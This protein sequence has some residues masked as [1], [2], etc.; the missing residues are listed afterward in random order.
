MTAR[1]RRACARA[2]KRCRPCFRRLRRAEKPIMR[3][4][5]RL[6][7]ATILIA[8]SSA[9]AGCGSMGKFRSFRPARLPRHQEEAAGRTQA[10]FPRRR[11]GPRA[12]RAEGSL[13]GL[14]P[15]A[16]RRA[17]CAGDRCAAAA[18]AAGAEIEGLEVQGQAGGCPQRCARTA[19][20]D[21]DAA[22]EEEGGTAAAPPGAAAQED[23]AQA[24]HR[25]AARAGSSIG[26]ARD[27]DATIR[28]T[29]PGADAERFVHALNA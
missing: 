24:H 18:A 11:A 5:Q 7:A 8:L 14:A 2:P 13:Q 27:I 6:I 9:L 4:P 12:G 21:P 25:A 16:D 28:R 3:R 29:V 17:E 23:R 22:P 19:A 26:R 10:G 20:A 15:A 1:R